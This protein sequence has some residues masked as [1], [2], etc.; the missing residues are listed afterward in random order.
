MLSNSGFEAC[1]SNAVFE[2]DSDEDDDIE[3]NLAQDM[4]QSSKQQSVEFSKY[5]Q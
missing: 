1:E 2:D 4:S 5:Q 3:S